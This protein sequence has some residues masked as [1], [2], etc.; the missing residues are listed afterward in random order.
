MA[1]YLRRVIENSG[2]HSFVWKHPNSLATE[3]GEKVDPVSIV[4]RRSDLTERPGVKP[5][6]STKFKT[7]W[8]NSMGL[9][10]SQ[11]LRILFN[12]EGF[13]WRTC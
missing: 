9:G 10:S 5:K 1:T 2:V 11:T 12:D 6:L 4:T 7:P 13:D 3:I 8:A